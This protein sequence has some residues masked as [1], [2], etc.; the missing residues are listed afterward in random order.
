MPVSAVRLA[1]HAFIVLLRSLAVI[2]G[3]AVPP[4]SRDSPD[5]DVTAVFRRVSLRAHPDKGGSL[6]DQK[7]PRTPQSAPEGARAPQSVPERPRTPQSA[8]ERPRPPPSAPK[9]PRA[10]QSAPERPIAPQSAL[11]HP[12]A[13]QSAPE[14]SRTPQSVP[15]R[16]INV[17]FLYIYIYIYKIIG[18]DE[19]KKSPQ[20][21][22]KFVEYESWL[23]PPPFPPRILTLMFCCSWA[24][25]GGIRFGLIIIYVYFRIGKYPGTALWGIAWG[26]AGIR[27]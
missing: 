24:L 26:L 6:Q 2:Y 27:G 25:R 17:T 22:Q 4:L 11:V 13:L 16:R 20:G 14:R 7:R 9:R 23:Y 8:S 19:H 18:R 15:E 10:P 12:R 5:A 3:L 1:K 21:G